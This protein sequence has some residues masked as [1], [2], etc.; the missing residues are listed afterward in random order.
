MDFIN[1]YLD[2]LR[3]TNEKIPIEKIKEIINILKE[4]YRKNKR[5]FLMGNGGSAS[6]ASHF[7]TDLSK[8]TYK[9]VLGKKSFK[10]TSLCDNIS[11][12]T[13]LSNDVSYDSAFKEQLVNLL[14]EGDVV[15][16]ISGSGNSKNVLNAMDYA[17]SVGA[18]TIGLTGFEGGKLKDVVKV[19]LTV[20]SNS[21]EMIEDMHLSISH[22]IKLVLKDELEKGK[23]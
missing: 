16:G 18:T 15:I 6:L 20:P 14:E 21:M 10:A 1:T 4:A 2:E 8:L 13:A 23:L 7:A 11:F 22:I 3:K 17:N 19:C 5:I 9:P 12:I